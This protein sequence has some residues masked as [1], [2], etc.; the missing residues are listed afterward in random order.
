MSRWIRIQVDI[1][2]HELFADTPY[3]ERE[4]WIWIITRAAWKDTSH[5]VGSTMLEV[6]R[7][8]FF[9][10][11]RQLQDAWKWRST[12]QVHQFLELLKSQNMIETETE[13]GKTL[14][15]VCNYDKYQ[16]NYL[17]DETQSETILKQNR[18]IKDT[19]TPIISSLR[20][21]ISADAPVKKK[22]LDEFKEELKAAGMSDDVL[23]DLIAHRRSKKAALTKRGATLVLAAATKCQLS[24]DQAAIKMIERNWIT[25]EPDWLKDKFQKPQRMTIAGAAVEA[26]ERMDNEQSEFN[27]LERQQGNRTVRDPSYWS[28]GRFALPKLPD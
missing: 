1:M 16:S 3:S 24:P 21:D 11:I 17:E 10:T 4:A 27:N 7:G 6:K 2:N 19:N 5:R 9:C 25:I 12:R 13:T 20:S 14:L 22:P 15:S 28:S 26:I 23:S 18:N 8:T